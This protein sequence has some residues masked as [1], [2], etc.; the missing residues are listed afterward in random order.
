MSR[1]SSLV[2][3][4]RAQEGLTQADLARR[5]GTTQSVIAR[6]ETP[7]SNPTLASLEAVLGAMNRKLELGPRPVL[8]DV[9]EGQIIE[10]LRMTPA[11]RLASFHASHRNMHEMLREAR[12]V[13]R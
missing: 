13:P 7:G 8:P 6:I 11:Q 10:H 5:A 12:R 4:A 3:D 1:A 2:R 9:D